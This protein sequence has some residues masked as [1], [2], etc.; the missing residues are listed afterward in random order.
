MLRRH[1]EALVFRSS[2]T[3]KDSK[4]PSFLNNS[5]TGNQL[6]KGIHARNWLIVRSLDYLQLETILSSPY[7]RDERFSLLVAGVIL[8]HLILSNCPL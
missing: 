6:F 1:T 5:A 3:A 2:K 4:R 8:Q 7:R